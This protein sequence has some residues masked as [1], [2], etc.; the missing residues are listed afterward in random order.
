MISLKYY[1]RQNK[2]TQKW[3]LLFLSRDKNYLTASF[4]AF[5]ALNFG[6]LVAATFTAS[7]VLG[8]RA[9]LAALCLTEK[10]PK[11]A[12]ETS[13]PFFRVPTIASNIPSTKIGRA[14]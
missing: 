12:I 7:P 8:L 9:I 13:P 5:A 3:V 1:N 10:I 14:H 6:T 2:N 4:K 11:P